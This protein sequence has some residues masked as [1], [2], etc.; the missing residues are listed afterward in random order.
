ME[1]HA[2][3][4]AALDEVARAEVKHPEW[5]QDLIHQAAII[6]EESGEMVRATLQAHYEDGPIGNVYTEAIHTLATTIRLLKNLKLA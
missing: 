2:I 1:V 4:E 3:I 6:S 5:P